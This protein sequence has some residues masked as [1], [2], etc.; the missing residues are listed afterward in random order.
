MGVL[1]EKTLYPTAGMTT[2]TDPTL[3]YVTVVSVTRSGVGY[4]WKSDGPFADTNYA[5]YGGYG[6]FEFL[7]PFNENETIHIL[8]KL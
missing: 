1:M 2:V 6:Q 8:Y 7:I 3:A 5:Y 4:Y